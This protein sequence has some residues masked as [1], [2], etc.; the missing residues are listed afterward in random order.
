MFYLFERGTVVVAVVRFYKSENE[1]SPQPPKLP[2]TVALDGLCS[3]RTGGDRACVWR[4]ERGATSL[5]H[6]RVG[7]SLEH[8]P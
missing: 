4:R 8:H 7:A 3:H 2:A 6:L 1:R 5:G